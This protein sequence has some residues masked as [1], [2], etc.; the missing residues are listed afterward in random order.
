MAW[1]SF[2]DLDFLRLWRGKGPQSSFQAAAWTR[3]PYFCPWVWVNSGLSGKSWVA[4]VQIGVADQKCRWSCQ[5]F[6]IQG[7]LPALLDVLLFNVC[8]SFSI[9][10]LI[11][12]LAAC[13]CLLS[14]HTFL[15]S[16]HIWAPSAAPC[17][18]TS[19]DTTSPHCQMCCACF[20]QFS[21]DGTSFYAN[22]D[23]SKNVLRLG[24]KAFWKC[25]PRHHQ[26]RM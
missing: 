10:L 5:S 8:N 14:Q 4:C 11:I 7:V 12:V 6:S 13:V 21:G 24:G 18:L 19:S 26:D 17:T 16:Q 15:H 1:A 2:G 22:T 3:P 20:G 25:V 9:F 23:A